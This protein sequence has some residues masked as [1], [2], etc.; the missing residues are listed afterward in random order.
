MTA[1]SANIHEL[2]ERQIEKLAAKLPLPEFSES[3]MLYHATEFVKSRAK[4]FACSLIDPNACKGSIGRRAFAE[5]IR[6]K[7]ESIRF[8]QW[9]TDHNAR[10]DN[11]RGK[12]LAWL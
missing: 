5:Y 3:D 6:D 2:T 12:F 1:F 4:S 8:Q 11:Q 9:L 10:F 7:K